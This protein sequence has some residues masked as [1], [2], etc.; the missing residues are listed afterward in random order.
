MIFLDRLERTNPTPDVALQ[1]ATNPCGEQPLLPY[2]ACVLGSLNLNWHL[3]N[4]RTRIDWNALRRDVHL[5]VRFLDD[6]VEASNFPL[7]ENRRHRQAR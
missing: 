3:T 6:M 5:S 7:E 2:E 1:D 4:D